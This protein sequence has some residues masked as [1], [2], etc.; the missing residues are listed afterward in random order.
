MKKFIFIP[1]CFVLAFFIVSCSENLD[2]SQGGFSESPVGYGSLSVN[3]NPAIQNS[4][5]FIDVNSIDTATVTVSGLGMDDKVVENV[6]VGGGKGSCTIEKIPIGKNRVVMIQSFK[7]GNIVQGM[8]LYGVTDIKQGA[9]SIYINVQTSKKGKVYAT[10]IKNGV[11]DFSGVDEVTPDANPALIDADAILDDK[12][13]GSL[14][15]KNDYLMKKAKVSF[16]VQVA[17]GQTQSLPEGVKFR[18]HLKNCNWQMKNLYYYSGNETNNNKWPGVPMNTAGDDV[19]VDMK[20]SW[21]SAGDTKLIFYGGSNSD[22]YPADRAPGIVLPAGKTEATYNLSMHAW[23]DTSVATQTSGLPTGTIIY[24]DDPL[25][26]QY[27]VLGSETTLSIEDVAPGLWNV[28]KQNGSDIK[29]MGKVSVGK[30]GAEV[31]QASHKVN[32]LDAGSDVP[33][34]SVTPPS[35]EDGGDGGDSGGDDGGDVVV[36]PSGTQQQITDKII[37]HA[38]YSHIWYWGGD[39]GKNS[40]AWPGT[41]MTADTGEWKK[42][43]LNGTKSNIIFSN[44]GSGQTADLSRTAGEWWYNGEWLAANPDDATPP[45]L[46][47]FSADKMGTVSGNVTFTISA[48]DNGALKSA[49]VSLDGSL[50]K[51]ISLSGTSCTATFVWDTSK[52]KNSSHTISCTVKDVGGNLSTAKIVSLTTNNANL[53][54]VAVISGPSAA[55]TG[56]EK[57]F[58]ASGSYDQNGGTISAYTWTVQG[59]TVK[60]GAGTE[61]LTV[62]MPSSTGTA[63]V[64]LKVKDDENAWSETVSQAVSVRESSSSGDFRE[65][66]IY[67]LMTT[68]FYDGDRSNNEYCWDEGGEYLEIVNGDPAWRGDFKGLA[69]KLDYIKAL[70]FSAVWIT[71]VVENASGIDYHGY[72][73]YDFSRVDPRYESN[74]F[75]YQDLINACHAKGIKVIQDIVL[76][77]T[78]NWGE[79]NLFH[80]FKKATSTTSKV[81]NGTTYGTMSKVMEVDDTE[82]YIAGSMGSVS[83]YESAAGGVQYER[84][85]IGA[86]KTDAIDTKHIYH[87]SGSLSWN[88][89]SVQTGQIAGD[90]VDLN[91]E[92]PEVMDYLIRCYKSYIDMGVD[93]FRVDTVKHISR[94]TLNETFN[95]EIKEYA[96]DDFFM[97]G[98]VCA[99][100]RGEVN[101]NCWCITPAFYTWKESGEPTWGSRA[102]NE[103]N[104]AANWEAKNSG[105]SH[106]TVSGG[107]SNH[108]LNGNTYHAPDWSKRSGMDV[109]D[110]YMHWAFNSTEDAYKTGLSYDADYCDPTWNVTYVDSH[111]YAPDNAPENKR[112]M[113]NWPDKLNLMFTFR[114]IPCIYYGSEIEFKKGLCIDPP[115]ERTS[116]EQSGRAYFGDNIEGTV[117]ASDFGTYT[118]SG[119]V[120]QTLNH[121]LAQHIIRLNQIRRAIPAL[122]KGQY[123]TQGCSGSIAFKRRY[124]DNNV[125]SFALVAINGG[126]TFSGI[127]GGRYVEVITG[128]STTVAEGG[129]LTTGTIGQDNMRVYVLTGTRGCE[130]SGKIGKDG[131]WLK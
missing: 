90:C 43:T 113:G 33:F 89:Y 44:N 15:T 27:T 81:V 105:W 79:K 58:S 74:T 11:S 101:E 64:T 116:L 9:N 71:P 83:A 34:S 97:F 38:K 130:V 73:A 21:V 117:Q 1:F 122:Q 128:S 42:Y 67:F 91:T 94:W 125:D 52:A 20:E 57:V 2:E 60:S 123:S 50:F 25:S 17:A 66:T 75:K 5:R 13:V 45:V 6:T 100:Y 68:R 41:A 40:E 104:A 3:Q 108:I 61:T 47:T 114:G 80:M 29:I 121:P 88:G 26:S 19:Y 102:S 36:T 22:R 99:R 59:A 127:P 65:E 7:S 69:E 103:A 106:P 39:C 54:P 78:G 119:K 31:P 77:H 4:A 72:H 14:K 95:K 10:L 124:T 18:V 93:A 84:G 70:G 32:L 49:E 63:T 98:E 51:S 23:E 126:A 86:M 96:G 35:G 131:T 46:A 120:A 30:T 37:V 55:K 28:Y 8:T 24:I 129:T 111:D 12:K 82:G 85:R 87:H 92:N 76:N 110:F 53:P 16:N 115:A 118:A 56:S 107:V 62:L 109:I 48:T 112:F